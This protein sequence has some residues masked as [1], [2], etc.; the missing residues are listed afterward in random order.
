MA[1]IWER[2]ALLQNTLSTARS[3]CGTGTI[4][5]SSCTQCPCSAAA[6]QQ[7]GCSLVVLPGQEPENRL[8]SAGKS[9]KKPSEEVSLLI[10]KWKKPIFPVWKSP[11]LSLLLSRKF[12]NHQPKAQLGQARAASFCPLN[13]WCLSKM[14]T[15]WGEMVE[16]WWFS[17]PAKA[18]LATVGLHII[19][20]H[21]TTQPVHVPR[22]GARINVSGLAKNFFFLLVSLLYVFSNACK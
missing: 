9:H 12:L 19:S 4:P 11:N 8:V 16:I 2:L 6:V 13:W 5:W 3:W 7:Q 22:G 1:L 10:R 15:T 21:Y 14:Q 17:S 20:V 18:S